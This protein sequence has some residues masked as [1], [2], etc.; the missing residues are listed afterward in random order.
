MGP[1]APIWVFLAR[2]RF[3]AKAPFMRVGFPWI[4]LDSLVR[5]E[6]FQWVTRLEAGKLFSR[7]FSLT[8]RGA[9]TG[10]CGRGHAEGQDCSRGKLNQISDFLQEIVV[11]P[12]SF[13]RCRSR[14]S[15]GRQ[16]ARTLKGEHSV[17]VALPDQSFETC[18]LPAAFLGRRAS[19]L[20]PF[21]DSVARR[22]RADFRRECDSWP[23]HSET[24]S[25]APAIGR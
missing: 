17:V 7:A 3:A 18:R 19:L 21:S 11:Q 13:A 1:V 9:G 10:A 15:L 8:L 22:G 2:G 12:T 14:I 24:H 16:E 20:G 4:S 23:G 5:I 6:T 25:P